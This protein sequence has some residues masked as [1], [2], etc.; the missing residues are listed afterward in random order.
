M[1]FTAQV[2]SACV[3]VTIA[4]VIGTWWVAPEENGFCSGAVC[5]SFIRTMTTSFGSICFGS[6]LVAIIR[7]LEAIARQARQSEDGAAAIIACI[8]GKLGLVKYFLF[9]AF[10]FLLLCFLFFPFFKLEY[11]EESFSNQILLFTFIL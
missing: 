6:L 2:L 9:F 10:F 1:F 7:S 5:N 11:I 3:H 8:C 4:G